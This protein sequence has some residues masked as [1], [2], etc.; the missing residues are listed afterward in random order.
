MRPSGRRRVGVGSLEYRYR[1][2]V[3]VVVTQGGR[4]TPRVG[5]AWPVLRITKKFERRS[6]ASH[7]HCC[8]TH[9]TR[10]HV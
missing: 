7:E 4:R 9:P 8:L 2:I 6:L 5:W 1:L 3:V 10:L